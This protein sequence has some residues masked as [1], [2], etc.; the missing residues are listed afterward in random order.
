MPAIAETSNWKIA[1]NAVQ[2]FSPG[3]GVTGKGSAGLTTRD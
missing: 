3:N 1:V 2:A